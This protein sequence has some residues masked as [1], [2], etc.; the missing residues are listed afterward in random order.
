M[1]KIDQTEGELFKKCPACN[2]KTPIEEC[3]QII[4][5]S[6]GKTTISWRCIV[7]YEIRNK[8]KQEI[9]KR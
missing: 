8:K 9:A 1:T 5:R 2:R 3:K 6:S 7:C 4:S